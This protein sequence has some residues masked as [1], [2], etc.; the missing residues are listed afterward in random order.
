MAIGGLWLFLAVLWVGLLCAIVVF[1]DHTHLLFEQQVLFRTAFPFVTSYL[2]VN[3]P[4]W[5]K[6]SKSMTSLK[7]FFYFS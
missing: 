1:P 4:G 7:Y 6:R 2:R 5:D 3:G